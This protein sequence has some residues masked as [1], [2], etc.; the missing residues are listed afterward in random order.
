[1]IEKQVPEISFIDELKPLYENL[2]KGDVRPIRK[3]INEN[4]QKAQELVNKYLNIIKSS[5]NKTK[6]TK[7]RLKVR[8]K[9]K[10]GK[11]TRKKKKR[12]KRRKV[13]SGGAE[14][15]PEPEPEP[16][17]EDDI[18]GICLER[19]ELT[20]KLRG[21][22]L[23]KCCGEIYH[24]ECLEKVTGPCPSC[25]APLTRGNRSPS[26]PPRRTRTRTGSAR[27]PSPTRH[28]NTLQGE[29]RQGE[30]HWW[31]NMMIPLI[32]SILYF[33]FARGTG[34]DEEP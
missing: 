25:R 34:G 24:T 23:L 26:P 21:E 13:K 1:M 9:S 2:I 32:S 30:N 19:L 11:K 3:W 4:P 15:G 8:V 14:P 5:L 33:I 29:T 17:T 20:G 7:A 6:S 31:E 28:P 18:C 27:G 12:Q 16:G 22:E 10:K